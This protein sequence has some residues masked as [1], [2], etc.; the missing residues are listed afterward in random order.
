MLGPLSIDTTDIRRPIFK[1][2]TINAGKTPALNVRNGVDLRIDHYPPPPAFYAGNMPSVLVAV[3]QT[4]IPPGLFTDAPDDRFT[5]ELTDMQL[6]NIRAGVMAVYIAGVIEY[7]DVFGD[8]HKTTF[9]L[10]TTGNL[11]G[12]EHR[13]KYTDDGNHLT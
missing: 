4:V 9:C 12:N 5:N 6:N 2:L 10:Y 1:R 7:E 13:M 3:G 8:S 11:Y